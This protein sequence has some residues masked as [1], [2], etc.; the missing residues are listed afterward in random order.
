MNHFPRPTTATLSVARTA[1]AASCPACGGVSIARY[2]VL[3]E[4]GWLTVVKCQTCFHSLERTAAHR[5]GS[6]HLL[7]ETL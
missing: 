2:P 3:A 7:S 4:E 1:V 6:I 5:L